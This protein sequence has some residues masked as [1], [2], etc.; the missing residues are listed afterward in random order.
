MG[1]TKNTGRILAGVLAVAVLLAL[2]LSAFYLAAEADHDCT[3]DD[4][5][6]CALLHQCEH[7]LRG[8]AAV[9]V[10]AAVL[11]AVLQLRAAADFACGVRRPTPVSVRVRLNN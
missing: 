3:G 2:L 4:C 7:L 6:V 8:Y 10:A 9:A 1:K 11:A 5:P